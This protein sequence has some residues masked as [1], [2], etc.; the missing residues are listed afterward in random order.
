ME[1]EDAHPLD[2]Y[3]QYSFLGSFAR[4]LLNYT[5]TSSSILSNISSIISRGTVGSLTED[6]QAKIVDIKRFEQCDDKA[7]REIGIGA[8]IQCNVRFVMPPEDLKKLETETDPVA[9]WMEGNGYV[10]KDTTTGLPKGYTPIDPASAQSGIRGFITGTVTS[11]TGQFID[12]RAASIEDYNDYAKFLDYCAYRKTPF[13]DTFE[14]DHPANGADMGW[15]TG[16]RCRERSTKLSNFRTYTVHKAVEEGIDTAYSG[17]TV[18]A[19]QT[20]TPGADDE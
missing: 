9:D 4:S 16:S 8:D 15:I 17:S 7:Y 5:S 1:S 12:E 18:P 14:D 13:G 11:F 10:E 6:A 2:I 19:A 3:N 20:T